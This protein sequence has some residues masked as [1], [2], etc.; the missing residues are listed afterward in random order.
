MDIK[1]EQECPQ[2]G[3]PVTLS[4]DDR[5]L[6]CAYC[7][8]K[9]FLLSQGPF[10]YALPDKVDPTERRHLIYAPYIRLKSNLFHVTE[11]GLSYKVIDTTQLGHELPGLPPSLGMR[12]Q[13]MK[14]Q[15]ITP[16]SKGK[17]LRLS[18]KAKVIME[19][20]VLLSRLS[21][22][23]GEQLL[24]RAYI[25]DTISIIYL[26]MLTDDTDLLDA[27]TIS[28]LS[29]LEQIQH[30]SLK[31]FGFN[32]RWQVQFLPTL[33]PKC[34]WNLEGEKDCIVPTCTNCE[35][36]WEIT[37]K[38]LRRIHWEVQ[39]GDITTEL[40]LPFWKITGQI[41]ALNIHTVTDF[42]RRT[43]QPIVPQP[44]LH[45]REMQFWIP[46][47]KLR[48]KKF[49]QVAR[50]ATTNHWRLHLEPGHHTPNLYPA[51]LSR[52]EARQSIKVVLAS[53]AVSPGRVLPYLPET[54]LKNARVSFA[55]L[56]FQDQGHDWVQPHT[57]AVISKNILR[58]G[59][60]L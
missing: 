23:V 43:N 51:N 12:P 9:S 15:R 22:E 53:C 1:V 58:F 19:K 16:E 10:R 27:V 30:Y 33:C 60:S 3:A 41:P 46:A 14:I 37:K 56:P 50:M 36:A 35:T 44:H 39:P 29:S 5:L 2:C 11:K 49:L 28:P 6:T 48:P 21:G 25:G 47:F 18:I 24:H 52:T 8:V 40:Y 38:G 45:D 7:G 4:E 54:K 20:A 57:G 31:G 13:V 17:F 55:F 34:G 26:P 59:R 32:P 42:I